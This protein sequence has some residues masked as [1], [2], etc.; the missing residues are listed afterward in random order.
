MLISVK[1]VTKYVIIIYA[2]DSVHENFGVWIKTF[3]KRSK[4]EIFGW[5]RQNERLSRT[6]LKQ[7]FLIN[8]DAELFI[9]LIQR[10]RFGSWN[11]RRLKRAQGH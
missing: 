7:E 9:Y 6:K 5:A 3:P 2:L 10:I 1:L 8:S 4:G 11:V